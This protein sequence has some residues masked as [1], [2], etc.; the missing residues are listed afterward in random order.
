MTE[1]LEIVDL[2]N[3]LNDDCPCTFKHKSVDCT[4]AV[5]HRIISCDVAGNVCTPAANNVRERME[6]GH[7]CDGC[8]R[9]AHKCW[10]VVAI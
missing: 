3:L 9:P 5:T 2:E 4:Q 8:L 7:L 6:A 10:R 1:T